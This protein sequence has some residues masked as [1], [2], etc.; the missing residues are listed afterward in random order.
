MELVQIKNKV[1][2]IVIDQL[3]YTRCDDGKSNDTVLA[4]VVQTPSSPDR[5][6]ITYETSFVSNLGADSL[7]V[8]ELVLAFE[9][10]F[11][12]D[13]PD[14]DTANLETMGDVINYI[15]SRTSDN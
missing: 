6:E 11:E 3:G 5:I 12:I 14:E 9:E 8:V 15:Q 13:I 7:A 10:A 2:S 1:L 4:V